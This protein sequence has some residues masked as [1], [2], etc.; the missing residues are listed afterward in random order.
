VRCTADSHD[1]EFEGYELLGC[2]DLWFGELQ[3][4]RWNSNQT[5][6]QQGLSG[7]LRRLLLVVS[8]LAYSST[9]KTEA[10]CSSKTSGFVRTVRHYSPESR[11]FH[12][13]NWLREELM[14]RFFEHGEE[15]SGYIKS[16]DFIG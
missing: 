16:R 10:I 3:A 2:N 14:E 9:L 7:K 1:G 8:C 15:L 5:R 13:L 6:I 4:S 12:G 11:A